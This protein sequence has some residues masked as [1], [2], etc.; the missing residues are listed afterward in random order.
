MTKD[1]LVTVKGLQFGDNEADSMEVVCNGTYYFR[2]G[3]H[4]IKY[5]E[6][7][8]DSM[9]S[10]SNILK[11]SDIAGIPRVEVKKKGTVEATLLFEEGQ[12]HISCYETDYG[13]FMLGFHANRISV[14]H[15]EDEINVHIDYAMEMNYEHLSDNQIEMN[16]VSKVKGA[17]L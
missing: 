12:N 9:R 4:Y 16:I 1:V 5:D 17:E 13:S 10:V 15:K 3:K 11:I 8:D 6:I 7:I 14:E 2:N